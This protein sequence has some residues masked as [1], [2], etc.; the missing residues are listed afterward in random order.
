MKTS[1]RINGELMNLSSPKVMGILNVTPDSF[2]EH[3]RV[4]STEAILQKAAQMLDDGA[5]M[6]DIG[7]QSTR[8]GAEH[9]SASEE[10]DRVLPAIE[11]I[12]KAFP[13]AVISIDTFHASVARDAIKAGAHIVNDVS[14]GK[15]DDEM[16]STVA[17]LKVPYILM[18]MKGKPQ[19][20]QED[21]QYG[22]VVGE[23]FSFFKSRLDML[24]RMGV[25]DVI[26]D[27]G[28]GFG[29]SLQHNYEL[30]LRMEEFHALGN[31]IL[32][33][34]SRK[35]MINKLLGTKA[36][37]ALN[38][39]TYLHAIALERGASIIR[40]HDVKEAIECVKIYNYTSELMKGDS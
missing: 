14:G 21:P 20:M 37:D 8:P 12:S 7:G 10:S 15:M 4:Q 24:N 1:I 35:S 22:D 27:P 9:I 6:L 32:I 39:T 17:Q 33:G 2:F 23:V 11:Q 19:T 38:G 31:P 30:L 40:V 28:F 16:F 36:K 29:K 25:V 34:V 5:D 13:Q 3:S 26:L 18:H